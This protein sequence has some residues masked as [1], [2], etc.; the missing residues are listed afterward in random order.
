MEP[1]A[2]FLDIDGT[3][4]SDGAVCEENIRAIE[5]ARKEG[6]FVLINTGRS[7]GN[8]PPYVL[9]ATE[10]DG[11]VCA[12]GADVRVRGQQIFSRRMKRKTLSEI[13]ELFLNQKDAVCIFEGEEETFRTTDM[14]WQYADF[15]I[16]SRH[17]LEEG[18]QEA[19]ISKFSCLPLDKALFEPFL[20]EL[21]LY[22][23]TAYYEFAQK[24]C[25][26]GSGMHIAAEHLSIPKNRCVAMGDSLNDIEMLE[27]AGIAVVMENG[28]ESVKAFADFLTDRVENGGVAKA[29][30]AILKREFSE[31]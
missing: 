7:Y 4:A 20:D 30:D 31:T 13:A 3:L 29:I 2:F 9:E 16:R 21:I 15:M 12:I 5:K 22:D 11:F 1:Y 19:N 23:H 26:K 27:E 6:H 14:H 8:I 24:G 28:A 17:V 10:Y 18:F 25:S